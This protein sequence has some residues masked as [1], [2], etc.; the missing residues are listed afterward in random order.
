MSLKYKMIRS[1]IFNEANKVEPI[2]PISAYKNLII[3]ILTIDFRY[4]HS[5]LYIFDYQKFRVY[6]HRLSLKTVEL[7]FISNICSY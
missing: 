3:F 5:T 2:N 1:F 6:V 4:L 7:F